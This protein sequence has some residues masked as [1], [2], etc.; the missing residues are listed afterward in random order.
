MSAAGI[1][2][3]L[4]GL[5]AFPFA[6]VARTPGRMAIFFAAWLIHIGTAFVYYGWV[7]TNSADTVLY[8]FD[9]YSMIRI[10][11][12]P[13]TILVVHMVQGLRESLG[14]TYLDYFLIFQAMG[15]W[16][17]VFVMRS[18]EEIYLELG[19]PQPR[20]A[21]LLLFLP[22]VHF[23]TSAIG[24]DAPLFLGASLAV[25]SAMQLR[26]RF[27]LFGFSVLVMVA[28][29]PHIGLVAL[30]GLAIAAIFDRRV[31][32]LAKV[33]LLL[34]AAGG[35]VLVAGTLETSLQV[36]VASAESIGDFF[37]RQSE[38]AGKTAGTTAV[39][40]A[41][42]PM[43]LFSLLFRPFFVDAEGAFGLIA[44][45]ENVF[46]MAV[47]AIFIRRFADLRRLVRQVFF[48][49]FALAFGGTII[50]LLAAVYYNVGLGLRQKVM[51]LP[52]LILL[53]VAML[54]VRQAERKPAVAYVPAPDAA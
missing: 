52:S 36:N 45:M 14:G 53:F 20:L 18:I 7:Q 11:L 17:I 9:P 54:A 13:G 26:R 29:R 51:F 2:G 49:R 35:S 43:K 41:S 24:K 40:G 10:P 12:K 23:W 21:Y 19:V 16:G 38:I 30:I 4:L 48:L 42:Y 39:V 8:Y 50:I 6:F 47:F 15:F 25:W 44:S 27:L 46:L 31:T 33:F 34:V 22:G 28:F 37:S 5:L 1:L 32:A 3:I